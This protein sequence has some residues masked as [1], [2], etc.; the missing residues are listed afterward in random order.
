MLASVLLA[1]CGGSSSSKPIYVFDGE[2]EDLNIYDVN[3]G[4]KKRVAYSGNEHEVRSDVP[5]LNG[6]ICFDPSGNKQFVM[7]DDGGQSH[8]ETPPGWAVMQ[9]SGTTIADFTA[10]RVAKLIPTYQPGNKDNFGC[11]YLKDGRVL[12][13]DIGNDANGP[14]SG[15]LTMFFPPFSG[16]SSLATN[17]CK[18]DIGIGTAGGIWLDDQERAYVASA[19]SDPGIWRYT[20]PFPTGPDAAHGCGKKDPVGSPLADNVMKEKFIPSD[21]DGALTPISI[22]ASGHGTWYVSSVLNGVIGEYDSSGKFV[23]RVLAPPMGDRFPY[24]TGNPQGIGVD[25]QGTLYYAD[26]GLFMGPNGIDTKE[27]GGTVRRIRFVNG[28]PQPPETMDTG[29]NFPDG[30]G[31]YEP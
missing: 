5:A 31:V 24:S 12:L 6:Q 30:I 21:N 28:Q 17:F 16:T 2:N 23:R 27:N 11:S 22:A 29:L 18:I 25:S 20:G 13:T 1:S 26:L 7:G 15:Q 3:N 10:A 8:P 4:F 9:L 19:R 14:A